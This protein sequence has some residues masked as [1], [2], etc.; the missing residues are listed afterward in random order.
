LKGFLRHRFERFVPLREDYITGEELKKGMPAIS[1]W[2][3]LSSLLA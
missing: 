3:S 1:G 2:V